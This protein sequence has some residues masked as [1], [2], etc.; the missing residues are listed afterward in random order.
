M[1]SLVEDQ[2]YSLRNLNIKAHALNTS[3]PRNEQ[4]EIMRILDG[5]NKTD[6]SVN[7]LYLTPGNQWIYDLF[8]YF[9]FFLLTK[10]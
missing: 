7:I 5:R 8:Y 10:Y 6:S 3:T 9:G 2:V 1:I 4:T